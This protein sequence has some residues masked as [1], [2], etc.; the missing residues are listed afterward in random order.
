MVT[1]KRGDAAPFGGG[2]AA[3]ER[4]RQHH[5]QTLPAG[6]VERI[7]GKPPAEWTESD[8]VDL[9]F[10]RGIR[11][12]TLMHI[13]GD[14]WLKTL[15]FVPRGLSHLK[16]I[17]AG[18]ERADGSSLFKGLGIAAGASDI[19]LRPKLSTAFLDPFSEMPA[20]VL[21]CGHRGRDGEPLPQS[22]ATVLRRAN[23]RL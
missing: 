8:L 17:L 19:V 14:G 10:D 18:G 16:D 1:I 20:L 7:I 6:L 11:L 23:E 9:V 21:L 5:A 15:D 4:E 13:G 12:I 3:Q 22:P 2:P